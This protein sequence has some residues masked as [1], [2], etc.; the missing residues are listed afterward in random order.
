MAAERQA[1]RFT[2]LIKNDGARWF[3]ETPQ[4]VTVLATLAQAYGEDSAEFKAY[5][6]QQQA[7]A[8]MLRTSTAF[9]ELGGDGAGR[10]ETAEDK[11]DRLA[12]ERATANK[13]SIPQAYTE[14]LAEDPS[15]YAA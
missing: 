15:L 6:A 9:Q 10:P 4:H 7:I 8:E 13:I 14:L 11:L 2:A 3:G 12:R 1:E 5:I